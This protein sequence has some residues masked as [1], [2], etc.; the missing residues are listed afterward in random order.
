M[1]NEN[2]T[3]AEILSREEIPSEYLGM[4]AEHFTAD[5]ST[6]PGTF[7]GMFLYHADLLDD[8]RM[9]ELVKEMAKP[10]L[11]I[12]E[13]N[14]LLSELSLLKSEKNKRSVYLRTIQTLEV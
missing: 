10:D 5:D 1:Q 6:S 7:K 11:T 13:K 9:E 12:E 14:N 2:L 4:I 8:A 3:A